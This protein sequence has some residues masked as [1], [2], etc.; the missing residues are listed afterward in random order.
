MRS[1]NVLVVA[2]VLGVFLAPGPARAQGHVP[3]GRDRLIGHFTGRGC[4]ASGLC[5]TIDIVID[6]PLRDD[7]A[8]GRI[9]YPSLHCDARLEFV[10][11][12]GETAVFRERYIHRATCIPDGWLWLR[13]TDVQRLD[14][15]WAYPDGRVDP[16]TSV[17]RS[18]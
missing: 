17:R 5:W 15:V 11:W 9:A 8:T 7:R 3:V 13:P 18:P 4:Q 14:F 2:A 12:E 16:H 10:R 1:V 6:P